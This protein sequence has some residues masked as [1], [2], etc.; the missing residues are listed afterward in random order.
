M[1]ERLLLPVDLTRK[2]DAA[3]D[4]V[5]DLLQEDGTVTLLH[6]IETIADA[7]FED[8]ED[9]YKRLEERAR[10]GM[11]EMAAGLSEKGLQVEQH[12]VYGR[13][14]AEIVAFAASWEADLILLSSAPLDP[15]NPS[16]AWASISHQVAILARSPVLLLK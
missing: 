12:V 11:S 14:A 8:M 9:F 7:P 5:C 16:A 6:V 15:E 3:L 4:V 13:R 1:F 2:N 10:S